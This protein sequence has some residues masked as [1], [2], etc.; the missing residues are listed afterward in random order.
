MLYKKNKNET[1]SQELFLNP[2]EEYRGSPFWAWN[3]KV[4]P[5]LIKRQIGYLKEMGFGGYHIHSRTGM[6]VP[7]LSDEF[8]DLI[9][10]CA[11]E[12]KKT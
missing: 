10:V 3:C 7:Y 9:K 5:D 1:L 8:M 6:D 2:T 4:T 12:A 11:E